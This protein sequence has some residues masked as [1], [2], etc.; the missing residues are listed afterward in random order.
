[1]F[2]LLLVFSGDSG[3]WGSLLQRQFATLGNVWR[4]WGLI[5]HCNAVVIEGEFMAAAHS[6]VLA[7]SK[8]CPLSV[9]RYK[10][11][12]Y[13]RSILLILMEK[14]L[15]WSGFQKLHSVICIQCMFR[16]Q[17]KGAG[18]EVIRKIAWNQSSC[19]FLPQSHSL[20]FFSCVLIRPNHIGSNS[21]LSPRGMDEYLR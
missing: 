17:G 15:P 2:N 3:H 16:N 21:N 13:L 19:L 20:H 8:Q 6:E 9:I 7:H 11:R 12:H 10:G 4:I 18:I 14:C 5:F 1:M